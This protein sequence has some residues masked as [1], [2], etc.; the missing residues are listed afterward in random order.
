MTGFV[1]Y[2]V[3]SLPALVDK[4]ESIFF[5]AEKFGS[6]ASITGLSAQVDLVTW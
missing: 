5:R 4:N 3:A 6:A 2:E 1:S